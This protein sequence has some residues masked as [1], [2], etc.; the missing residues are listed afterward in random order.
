MTHDTGN[1]S[2]DIDRQLE[3]LLEDD[4]FLDALSRGEDPSGGED[5]L[6]TLFLELR[7]QVVAGTETAEAPA[8]SAPHTAPVADLDRARAARR[9]TAGAHRAPARPR[10]YGLLQGLIGAAAATL[11]IAGGG[12][13]IYN[14]GPSSPL[15]G[16]NQALFGNHAAAVQLASTL[17]EAD[18]RS[19]KGD[20]AGALALLEQAKNMSQDLKGRD[21]SAAE[22]K[23]A[24]T[25]A[26]VT[27][28]VTETVTLTP[29]PAPEQTRE[30]VPAPTLQPEPTQSPVPSSAPVPHP[31]EVQ[32][33]APQRPAP[34]S[35]PA[36]PTAAPTPQQPA[37]S[38]RPVEPTAGHVGDH[39]ET[40]HNPAS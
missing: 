23:I 30:P 27:E 36:A 22:K 20:V 24:Q 16:A 3:Q 15:W 2:G 10:A 12:A 38:T 18:D 6:A 33:P 31:S 26:T 34:A 21:R 40:S 1:G 28:T 25:Q 8:A 37:P 9:D 4:A 13:T 17:Q 35:P 5:P 29:A 32:S 19:N 7:G 14:A 11:L 39:A